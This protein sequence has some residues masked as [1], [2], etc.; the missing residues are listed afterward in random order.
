MSGWTD[1]RISTQN[2]E[3]IGS[4]TATAENES[5]PAETSAGESLTLS[6]RFPLRKIGDLFRGKLRSSGSYTIKSFNH[7]V[8]QECKISECLT[9]DVEN[10]SSPVKKPERPVPTVEIETEVVNE[11]PV[12]NG[13]GTVTTAP[14]VRPRK[15]T[16][17]NRTFQRKRSTNTSTIGYSSSQKPADVVAEPAGNGQKRPSISS[18]DTGVGSDV[19]VGKGTGRERVNSTSHYS[20]EKSGSSGYYST[21]IFFAGGSVVDE[22]IYY[23]PVDRG[24]KQ[25]EEG[26][27]NK[28]TETVPKRE[29]ILKNSRAIQEPPPSPK[30]ERPLEQYYYPATLENVPNDQTIMRAKTVVNEKQPDIVEGPDGPIPRPIW[31]SDADDSLA[32]INLEAFRLRHSSQQNLIGFDSSASSNSD[33][34]IYSVSQ[35]NAEDQAKK[36]S[37]YEEYLEF[38]NTRNILEQIRG[39]L[40]TLLD[41]RN[42]NLRANSGNDHTMPTPAEIELEEKIANLKA[43]LE[44]Y[45][46]SMNQQNENEI[47][48]FVKGMSKDAKVMAVQNAVEHRNRSR[49]SSIQLENEYEVM[50]N[51]RPRQS[52]YTVHPQ[53]I[54]KSYSRQERGPADQQS[55]FET[56]YVQDGFDIRQLNRPVPNPFA[57]E[58]RTTQIL[59]SQQQNLRAMCSQKRYLTSDEIKVC[60][61]FEGRGRRPSRVSIEVPGRGRDGVHVVGGGGGGGM[62]GRH[63]RQSEISNSNNLGKSSDVSGFTLQRVIL[64]ES[65][66]KSGKLFGD[67]EKMLLEY[68]LNKPSYWE[69]YYG[70]NRE[71]HNP[72]HTLIRKVKIGGK[73]AISVSYPS[74]RP[75]SDF[76]LDLPRA[77]Q[78]RVKMKKEKQFRTRCRW[79]FYFLS[80]V[81]FLLS[82]MV[83]SLILTRGKRMFGSM[84]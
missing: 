36:K 57:Q 79:F 60:N 53:R 59:H 65:L 13:D 81:F 6:S 15:I 3:N 73:N 7:S 44:E 58:A 42:E 8:A 56:V 51:P 33:N 55:H 35:K 54:M 14:P 75:E 10:I 18:Q 70:A 45:L 80:V 69:L 49:S 39:K 1:K 48:R 40:D 37:Q 74:T 16:T 61:S 24:R 31:P 4:N 34:E 28:P 29:G 20:T 32:D 41:Q 66:G 25:S 30:N 64:M 26:A 17:L 52:F 11:K 43:D 78:L 63:R 23:E 68:H 76:T 47:N 50:D 67:K 2:A 5:K 9:L 77:E 46:R 84:I 22:H 82:V 21:N 72:H 27:G 38:H 71:E 62:D 83:V 19:V 12:R